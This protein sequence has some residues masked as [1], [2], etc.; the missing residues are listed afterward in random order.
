MAL[1]LKVV[2]LGVVVMFCAVEKKV[3]LFAGI[4]SL[5]VGAPCEEIGV[6]ELVD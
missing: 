1:V 6:E 3:T 5:N 4:L 2:V